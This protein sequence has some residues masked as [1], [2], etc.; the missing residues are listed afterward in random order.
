[1]SARGLRFAL[2]CSYMRTEDEI[3]QW[4]KER[5]EFE[6]RNAPE[7]NAVASNFSKGMTMGA[8]EV[9]D[10]FEKFLGGDDEA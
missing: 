4:L 8:L 10:A 3:S 6:R 1:M 7:S 5:Q 2:R 9:L